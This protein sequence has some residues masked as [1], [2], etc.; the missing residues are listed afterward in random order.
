MA[1]ARDSALAAPAASNARLAAMSDMPAFGRAPFRPF[2]I[3]NPHHALKAPDSLYDSG[4]TARQPR[5]NQASVTPA[6]P[7]DRSP[8][9]VEFAC[10]LPVFAGLRT[11]V[12]R[13]RGVEATKF[14]F[15]TQRVHVAVSRFPSSRSRERWGIE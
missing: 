1:S 8:S 3:H 5:C 10:R 11:R 9:T 15:Q 2:D 7:E 12:R 6:R 4:A 14:A 13:P